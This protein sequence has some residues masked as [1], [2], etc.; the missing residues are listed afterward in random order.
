MSDNFSYGVKFQ[1]RKTLVVYVLEDGGVEVRAPHGMSQKHIVRFIEEKS[2]WIEKTRARQ[3]QR[4][5]WQTLIEPGASLWFLGKPRRLEVKQD[6][7]A[8]IL[9][10]EESI[11]VNTRDPWSLP[12][13]SRQLNDWY[14]EQ[15]QTIFQQRLLLACQR[16]P[17]ILA[18]P[19][20]RL[21]RM[22]RRWGSCSRSGRVTL[23]VELV[24]LPP[25]IIDYIITH[26]LC[27]LTEFNHGKKFYKLLEHVMPDWKQRELIL[28]QF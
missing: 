25:T 14:R 1:A 22:R 26:E 12:A 15:A 18:A 8:A 17:G 9:C 21:R 28:K 3:V 23:N 27:H 11:V 20:L 16:F 19:E 24:K 6:Q 10:G 7:R 5:Q 13:L 4:Q 2:A